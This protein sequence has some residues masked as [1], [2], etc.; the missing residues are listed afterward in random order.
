MIHLFGSQS[1][2]C[3]W[4]L[5]NSGGMVASTERGQVCSLFLLEIENRFR[6]TY[7]CQLKKE[8]FRNND[9]QTYQCFGIPLILAFYV[10][11][12]KK[13]AMESIFLCA[14]QEYGN[15]IHQTQQRVLGLAH[16]AS[17]SPSLI[18][19]KKNFEPK[20]NEADHLISKYCILLCNSKLVQ[21]WLNLGG[22][23]G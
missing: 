18:K 23:R 10:S 8:K 15:R 5:G 12:N 11:K 17:L 2:H 19:L 6:R 3:T 14:M 21:I 13:Q 20:H 9:I 22:I 1:E 7:T 4:R 16:S